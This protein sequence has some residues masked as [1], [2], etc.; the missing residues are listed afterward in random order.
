MPK[1]RQLNREEK[2]TRAIDMRK[3]HRD[4]KKAEKL[5]N[6]VMRSL[7]T[8]PDRKLAKEFLMKSFEQLGLIYFTRGR[9]GRSLYYFNRAIALA[10]E[11]D[12]KKTYNYERILAISTRVYVARGRRDLAAEIFA[13]IIGRL[14]A[15]GIFRLAAVIIDL[16][17]EFLRANHEK[18][19]S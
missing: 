18:E 12:T 5:I 14:I 1:H 17:K 11:I 19:A 7:K 10:K 6:S 4:L 15:R 2:L 9:N 8:E 13:K 3:K 16:Y